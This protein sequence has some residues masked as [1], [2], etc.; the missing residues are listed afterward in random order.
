MNTFFLAS[1][2]LMNSVMALSD[3]ISQDIRVIILPYN[4][5]CDV[6]DNSAIVIPNDLLAKYQLGHGDVDIV[7][8]TRFSVLYNEESVTAGKPKTS[9]FISKRKE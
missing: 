1:D 5:T 4:H 3:H 9:R 8:Y 6:Y 7:E 2:N